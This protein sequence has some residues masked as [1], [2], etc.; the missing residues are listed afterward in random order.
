MKFPKLS[1]NFLFLCVLYT[2]V[3]LIGLFVLCLSWLPP[4]YALVGHDSGLPLDSKEFLKT[5]LLAWDDR[6]GF[7]LD[8]SANFGSLTIHFFD[9]LSSLIAGVPY[10]GNFISLFFW[11]GLILFSGFIFAYQ[12][13]DIFGKP[14]VFILPVLLTF[15]FYIFQSV[16]MLE[17]AKFGIFSAILISL[18]VFLRMQD[19]KLPIVTSA[20]ITAFVFSIFNGGGWFGITLYGG[21]VIILAVLIFTSFI[22]GLVDHNFDEFKRT[23]KFI[24]LSLILYFLLNAYAIVSY[25][26]NFL[27]TDAPRLLQESSAESHKDWLRYVS[28]ST[29]FLNL[30]SLFGV[31]DWYSEINDPN[32]INLS[33]AYASVYLSNKSLVLISFIFPILTFASLLLAKHKK[34]KQIIGFFGLVTL[35]EIVFAAG[36]NSP[37][38]LFYEFL[39]DNVP[40]FFIFRSAFYKFGVFYMLGMMVMFAFTLSFL[41]EKL[42]SKI[43]GSTTYWIGNISHLLLLLLVLGL[44]LSYHFVLFDSQKVFAWKVDQSTKMQVPAYIY[45]F[46]KF[47]EEN[48]L[49]EKRVLMVPPVNQ[50]WQS[51]AYNWGYW[52]LSPAPFALSSVRTVS[53]WHGLT[54]EELNLVDSLYNFIK[55]KD[56]KSFLELASRLNIGYILIRQ[57]VLTDSKWSAS[58]KP[59]NYK[60]ILES[61]KTVSPLA[62]FGPW[63]LYQLNSA[64]PMQAYTTFSGNLTAD[65]Y[66]ILVN[67]LFTN[68]HTIGLSDRKKYPEIDNITSNK[69]YAYD[70]LSC[71]LE[72]QAHLKPLPDVIILPGSL[73]YQFKEAREQEVLIQSKS[74]RSKIADYL[75]FISTRTAELKRMLDLSIKEERLLDNMGVIRLYLGKMYSEIESSEDASVDFELLNQLL[76]YLNPVEREISDYLKTSVS[77]TRSHRFGEE[78]LGI[79]WDI[80]RIK[81]YFAS[82]LGDRKRF[83][84]EK[85]YKVTFPEAGN[86]NLLFSSETFPRTAEGQ[87]LVPKQV[88]FIKGMDEKLLKL[89]EDTEGW[90]SADLGYQDKA[91]VKLFLYFEELPNLFNVEE[92]GLEKFPFGELGCFN[93]HIKNFDRKMAYEVLISK[94]NRLGIV[95][96]IFRDKNKLY[97][98]EHGFLKGEDLFEVPAS[99][100]GEFSKYI[101][102]PS[103]YAKD[104][105]LYVCGDDKIVPSIEKIV[106][107]E[108]FSPSAI[109]VKKSSLV[110]Q[111]P[112]GVN[113]RRVNPTSY[114]GEVQQAT[115][116]FIFIFNEKINPLWRLTISN[117]SGGWETVDKHFM[118]DGYANGWL[119][120]KGQARK[121]KIE[122]IPQ[123]WFLI[124][125]IISASVFLLS[126]FWLIYSTI[127]FKKKGNNGH[128]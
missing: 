128:I 102:F 10:A 97:S 111:T 98:E 123:S 79:L 41:I 94:T 17:R 47:V 12:L 85:F 45:D 2:V 115:N 49:S 61:F 11:L 28:R 62:S 25:L 40:G 24:G 44:W 74:S 29:S 30:F 34:Q 42:V 106:V 58:E 117:D 103:S 88:K 107:R 108:F 36:S 77:K 83:S 60:A 19:R 80:N 67:K 113:F 16:F 63:E 46:A 89:T 15:N 91:D 4:G 90:F 92:T 104:I 32:R 26:P 39:I 38:G 18:A 96:A 51:D 125:S 53:N 78:M 82:I 69:V 93:G 100:P 35:L 126:V 99:A 114:V 75:G 8:N 33:H 43:R 70:C 119:M 109:I 101:Y 6:L 14:F 76:D 27:S 87:L 13:K 59:D 22:R 65:N 110:V 84:N 31:P 73:F 21:L 121:F 127:G 5:R 118:I 124:G 72:R 55:V 57:D 105:V 122:Y 66:V 54:S 23:F 52:S 81:E 68:Q 112:P 20:V 3:L 116:P 71:L 64:T 50:D 48:H 37:F 56:E 9:L 7:G 86:Y 95:T 120:E 1:N